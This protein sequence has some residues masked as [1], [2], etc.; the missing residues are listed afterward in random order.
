MTAGL[1]GCWARKAVACA[2]IG[3]GLSAHAALAAGA[4]VAADLEKDL[5]FF[6]DFDSKPQINGVAFD[7]NIKPTETVEGRYGKAVYFHRHV[8]NALPP[9]SEFLGSPSG[10]IRVEKGEKTFPEVKDPLGYTWVHASGGATFSL[11]VKG[12]KGTVVTLTPSLS[13]TL[14]RTVKDAVRKYKLD[15]AKQVPDKPVATTNVLD[16]TWQRVWAYVRHDCRTTA[17]RKMTLT[18]ATTGPVEMERF[19]CEQSGVYPYRDVFA[20]ALWTE[21]GTK[22]E[23]VTQ[24]VTDPALLQDFPTNS[25]SAAFWVRSVKDD[26]YAQNCRAFSFCEDR[27]REYSF[28][29]RLRAGQFF[30]ALTPSRDRML[31]RSDEWQHVAVTW[32]PTNYS[33]YVNGELREHWDRR[34]QLAEGGGRRELRIGTAS[35][36]RNSGDLILD[37]VAIFR[38]PLAAEEVAALAKRTKGLLADSVSLLATPVHFPYFWRNQ[39]DAALRTVVTASAAG[40]W[41]LIGTVGGKPL[42]KKTVRFEKGENKVAAAFDPARFRPGKYPWR[43][44][45]VGKDGREALVREGT[46]E[47]RGRLDRA[48]PTYLSWGGNQGIRYDFMRVMGLDAQNIDASNL[49]AA[50]KAVE[51]GFIPNVRYGNYWGWKIHDFDFG[52][53]ERAAERVFAPYEGLWSWCMTL[54]NTEVYGTGIVNEAKKYPQFL[55]QAEK[56]IGMKPDFTFDHSPSQVRWRDLGMKPP[57]GVLGPTNAT[58]ETLAW[59]CDR[60]QPVFA[61]NA[62][63][64]RAIHRLSPGN[65]VWT[66][67]CCGPGGLAGNV[68][69]LADWYYST[70][71][72]ETLSDQLNCVGRIRGFD[73]PFMP[74]LCT[75]TKAPGQHPTRVGKD[76]KPERMTMGQS[77]GELAV[78]THVAI[79]ATRSDRLSMFAA[80]CWQQGLKDY[81][82]WTESPTNK[83]SCI[84]DP[85][86]PARYGRLVR[87][88]IM[89]EIELLRG[90]ENV[91]APVA[92]LEPMEPNIAGGFGWNHWHHMRGVRQAVCRQAVPFDVVGD[93]E[94]DDGKVLSKYR[95]LIFPMACV[96][97]EKHHAALKEAAKNGSTVVLDEHA[98]VDYPGSVKVVAKEL[99]GWYTNRVEELR[100][101]LP[102]ASSCDYGENGYTFEKRYNGVRYVMVVN[103]KRKERSEGG[104]VLLTFCTNSWYRPYCAPQRVMTTLRGVPKGAKVYEF[105]AGG[106]DRKDRKDRKDERDGKDVRITRDFEAAE[107]VVY[108]VYPEPL[109]APELS[110]SSLSSSVLGLGV[111]ISTVSGKPAPGRTIVRVTVTDSDGRVTDESGRYAV[112]NGKT[113]IPI[114]FADEDL[115]GDAAAKWK[116]VVVDLMTGETSALSFAR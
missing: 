101:L 49:P 60:G 29:G 20:P 75:Y 41:T 67:P 98:A 30:D 12:A 13:P 38:R 8:E 32:A 109:K 56:E 86:A 74:T 2:A 94:M 69:M 52:A 113:V 64:R 9:M 103:N 16:G 44:A 106:K 93:R 7:L 88:R 34:I 25:G 115:D 26:W 87:T 85:D 95:C 57:R 47:I 108:C 10:R 83:V 73:L 48:A 77:F 24:Y 63:A 1:V 55:A 53:I 72:N 27:N 61:L 65:I 89:P 37:E 11:Y 5:W 17:G 14:E 36:G 51:N 46:L 54:V 107:G 43:F 90:M 33:F 100:A 31:M 82:K 70:S 66:E 76:G 62:A 59:L 92:F 114:R 105:N 91:R 112:E 81:A 99:T 22:R 104:G 58:V 71:V 79:G 110:V 111:K 40:E 84:C 68:D 28:D 3:F 42:A 19:Q 78:K 97:T 102:S 15:P 80:D 116:V 96:V 45:L 6:A 18:V 39:T 23:D 50:R 4:A 21:G 35:N